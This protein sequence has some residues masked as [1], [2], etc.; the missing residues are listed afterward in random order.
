MKIDQQKRLRSVFIQVWS[1]VFCP[2]ELSPNDYL[3]RDNFI[4]YMRKVINYFFDNA[5]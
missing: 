1:D 5:L 4:D 3:T 2:A